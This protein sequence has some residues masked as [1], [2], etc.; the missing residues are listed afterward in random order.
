MGNLKSLDLLKYQ[1]SDFQNGDKNICI[2]WSMGMLN[3]I[4]RARLAN[5]DK[6]G[7]AQW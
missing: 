6:T 4:I 3:E 5:I 1:F 2:L 7:L